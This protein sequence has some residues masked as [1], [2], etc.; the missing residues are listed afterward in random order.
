M[1]NNCSIA[2]DMRMPSPIP[3]SWA[4]WQTGFAEEQVIYGDSNI[5]WKADEY[6]Y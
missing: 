5:S 1:M 6:H 2:T 3:G 4:F